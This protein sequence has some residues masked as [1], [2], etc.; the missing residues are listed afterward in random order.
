MRS[1][2][3]KE[4]PWSNMATLTI[5]VTLVFTL[6]LGEALLVR[7]FSFG[8]ASWRDVAAD[9]GAGHIMLWGLR[10]IFL[11]GYD[12]VYCLWTLNLLA[13]FHPLVVYLVSFTIWDFTYYW[14]HRV[15]HAIP[16]LWNVHAV[17]HQSEHYGL[18]VGVRN[19]YLEGLCEFPFFIPLA[20]LGVTTEVLI[21][22]SSINYF[23][24]FYNHNQLV[25]RQGVLEL[26][27]ITPSHH[28]LHH[29]INYVNK[30]FGGTLLVWDKIFGTYQRE[31]PEN[32][33]IYGVTDGTYSYNP[34][35]ANLNP[36]LRSIGLKPRGTV[37]T[38]TQC[39]HRFVGFSSS[40]T[41]ALLWVYITH[42][43]VLTATQRVYLFLI[44]FSATVIMGAIC[45]GSQ[46]AMWFWATAAA[47][48]AALLFC[49]SVTFLMFMVNVLF[50]ASGIWALKLALSRREPPEP[51]RSSP[52]DGQ[53]RLAV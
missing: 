50:M 25:K 1:E 28:R 13:G 22:V 7:V 10:G 20:I 53:G 31:L 48:G 47:V 12:R 45:C 37:P 14:S 24:M 2:Q 27:L 15:R 41:L 34:I 18:A 33:P 46:R 6:T 40:V 19:G 39:P 52:G 51:P 23:I 30:N 32:S 44:T 17:H 11:A 35:W 8:S 42:E 4:H 26:F 43:G 16:L 9:L 3:P 5:A 36:F 29:A 38:N 21:A 49:P